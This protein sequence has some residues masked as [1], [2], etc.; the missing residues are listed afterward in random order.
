MARLLAVL[1]RTRRDDS[2]TSSAHESVHFHQGPAGRPVVCHDERCA[3]P[4]L[5]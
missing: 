4:R 1:G 2:S 3:S 5:D